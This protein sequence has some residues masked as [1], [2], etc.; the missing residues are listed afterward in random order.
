M[1][2]HFN[3]IFI[4]FLI[5]SMVACTFPSFV[6]AATDDEADDIK[7]SIDADEVLDL[8]DDDFN[9]ACDDVN[10]EELD[11]IKFALPDDDDG[12]LYY[13]Y[14]EDDDE[15][16]LTEV[17]ATKKYYFDDTPRLSDV[18]FVPDEDYSGT[19]TIDYKGYDTDG[20]SYSGEI[21]VTISESD[22][23]EI[24]TYSADEEEAVEFDEDDFFDA[25][26]E[27]QNEDLD[28]VKF[29]LP[30]DD[31]GI[32]YYDYDE[33]DSSHTKVSATKKYYYTDE[34]PYI[35]K[36][37]FVPDEDFSDTVTIKY[38]GYDVDGD[39]YSAK[40]KITIGEDD[41]ST[42]TE[43]ISYK[44]EDN[45]K[46]LDFDEDDFNDVCDE[47]NNQELD[48]VKFTIP[49]ATKGILYYN[50]SD[51]DYSSIV[52]SGKQYYYDS[53]PYIS[54]VTFVP[55]DDFTGVCK[56]EYKGYDTDG[57]TFS[58]T[59]SI[60]VGSSTTETAKIISYSSKTNTATVF[61]DEDFNT[62]C[63]TLMDTQLSYVTFSLPSSSSGTLYY[64]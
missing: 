42:S 1:K 17:S 41:S 12:M 27:I 46:T 38:T 51:G 58:G 54:K 4:S 39:S 60:T 40:V 20:N 55:D 30:D 7:Y 14:D 19:L 52:S 57:D 61:K 28:Y 63:K 31:D 3:R 11:Y 24:I 13:K 6:F 53:S 62:V 34:S 33:D 15:D 21:K 23:P 16:E 10:G 5:I 48:Y 47:K 8:D 37:T 9:D 50:Y 35:S 56:V 45:D 49:S 59:V 2:K 29:T 64:G 43:I 22:D 18:T 44:I 36:V 32:L 26:D 25:C